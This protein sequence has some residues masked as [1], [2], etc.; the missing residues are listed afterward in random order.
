M[1]WMGV[2]AEEKPSRPIS[3]GIYVISVGITA[4]LRLVV[5]PHDFLTLT[6]ALP[7]LICIFQRDRV[8]LWAMSASFVAMSA[9]KT[10]V[11]RGVLEPFDYAQWGMQVLNILVTAVIVDVIVRMG[12]KLAEKHRVLEQSNAELAAR[13]E[14]I[15]RQNEELQS[16]G[17]E[18]A[19]QNEELEHQAEE[20]QTQSED[21]AALNA[22][23]TQREGV[24]QAIL[25]SI[26]VPG[27]ERQVMD[28]ISRTLLRLF[29]EENTAV[30][31][32]EQVNDQVEVRAWAGKDM[33]ALKSWSIKNSFTNIVIS[34]NRTAAVDLSKRGDIRSPGESGINYCSVLAAPLVIQGKI[35]GAVKAYSKIPRVWT[36]E[37]FRLIEWISRHCSMA[38]DVL[39]L[40]SQLGEL[41]ANLEQA[42]H[43]RTAELSEMVEELEH[44]SYTI[45]HDMRAP[46]RAIQGFAGMLR[47][48]GLLDKDPEAAECLE[49]ITRSAQRMDR[50]ITDA[51]S[52][53]KAVR[54]E[55]ALVPVDAEELLR[56]IIYS[57]PTLQPPSSQIHVERGIP[58]VLGNEAGLTQCFSNL[59]TNAVKFVKPGVV[60]QIRVS[61]EQIDG[62]VRIWF[63]DNGIGIPVSAQKN[64]FKMFQR[65]SKEYEG[66]GIGLALVRKVAS[67]MR[68]RVG[69]EPNPGG[70]SSFWL[71]FAAAPAPKRAHAMN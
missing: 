41:N 6:Y 28:D 30:A 66:T 8:L 1:N 31:I 23:L 45:T 48:I 32:V 52:Y 63:H 16:Q 44:F 7:L 62:H 15:S 65:G 3:F 37:Q 14:E 35:C 24:L 64:L 57:Y 13:E 69:V 36:R 18:L 58:K 43:T 33:P 4:W 59:L 10:F 51:L 34:E 71:E 49:H 61:A 50:L 5:F 12:R 25:S 11:V 19:Q 22:E 17:E 26:R 56:G 27:D 47:E 53:S 68:G 2:V 60:P 9:Y 39:R 20:L 54:Q 38:L 29:G 42:I 55:L 70:G 40:R 67:R 46:L 21:L